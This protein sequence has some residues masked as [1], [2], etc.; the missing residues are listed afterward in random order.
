M[1]RG[2]GDGLISVF[3]N[4]LGYI[5]RAMQVE[6]VCRKVLRVTKI[7]YLWTVSADIKSPCMTD[8]YL[9]ELIFAIQVG[10][11]CRKVHFVTITIKNWLLD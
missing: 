4:E 5:A 9:I 3:V 8:I 10:T 6:T 7:Y 2:S 1:G 11:V